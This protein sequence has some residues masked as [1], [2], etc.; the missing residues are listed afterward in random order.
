MS[1]TRLCVLDEPMYHVAARAPVLRTN[2][3]PERLGRTKSTVEM[4][5]PE[6][7]EAVS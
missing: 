2:L 1:K 6:A 3:V 7:V 4:L 5:R